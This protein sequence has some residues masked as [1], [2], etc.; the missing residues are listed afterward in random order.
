MPESFQ[1]E[2]YGFKQEHRTLATGRIHRAQRVVLR[3]IFWHWM[4]AETIVENQT[5]N[6]L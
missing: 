3:H 5:R 1:H 2:E 6:L 4:A